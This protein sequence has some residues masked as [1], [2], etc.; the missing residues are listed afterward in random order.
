MRFGFE[1]WFP[2]S[3]HDEVLDYRLSRSGR[4]FADFEAQGFMEI[5]P[6][7]YRKYRKTG[8]ATPSGKVELSSSVLGDLGFDPLPYFRPG[9]ATSEEFP[10]LVFNGVREDPF[11]Q[12]GQR[13][14]KELRDRCPVPRIFMHPD[15]AKREDLTD[16]EWIELQ[17][18]YGAVSAELSV[19]PN[20]K[21]G[22]LRVPHGWWYRRR[23][24]PKRWPAR[25]CR[26]MRCC[27]R[28]T[29]S[30]WITSRAFPISRVPG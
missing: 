18:A 22:H 21:T 1:E 13:N 12:T 2:W 30:F 8:F 4:S 26:V 28:T 14:I 23:R 17:T 7:K 3:T 9:P 27:A 25:F 19:Q 24:I 16:G 20:M 6:A 5:P 29:T 11:F 15:D 10:Y